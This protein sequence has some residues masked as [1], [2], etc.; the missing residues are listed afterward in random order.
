MSLFSERMIKRRLCKASA[1][2]I[3]RVRP[4]TTMIL[5]ATTGSSL[6]QTRARAVSKHSAAANEWFASGSLSVVDVLVFTQPGWSLFT[7][8]GMNWSPTYKHL[9]P[10]NQTTSVAQCTGGLREWVICFPWSGGWTAAET[11]GQSIVCC[12]GDHLK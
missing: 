3:E 12:A 5:G 11:I 2:W 9:P 6:N 10:V 8:R 4:S 7:V 1:T